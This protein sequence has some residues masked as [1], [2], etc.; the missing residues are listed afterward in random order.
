MHTQRR[1]SHEKDSD[2]FR[3]THSLREWAATIIHSFMTVR[4]E[5]IQ[6]E[7]SSKEEAT[8]MSGS[9]NI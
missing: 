2:M 4:K 3:A 7:A 8:I 5:K 6:K 1:E 9:I